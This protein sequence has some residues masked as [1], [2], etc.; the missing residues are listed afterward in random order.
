MSRGF[1][2]SRGVAICERARV[3]LEAMDGSPFQRLPAIGE[4]P[5]LDGPG[6]YGT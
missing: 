2:V 3:A 1:G 5:H 6:R 4:S